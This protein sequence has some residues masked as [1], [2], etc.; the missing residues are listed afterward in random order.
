LRLAAGPV[1]Q[2]FFKDG[3]ATSARIAPENRKI[4]FPSRKQPRQAGNSGILSF[5]GHF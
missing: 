4:E 2:R 3:F 5:F 1:G